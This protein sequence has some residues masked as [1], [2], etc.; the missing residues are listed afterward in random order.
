MA[1][2]A[3]FVLL[4]STCLFDLLGCCKKIELQAWVSRENT[5]VYSDHVGDAQVVSFNLQAGDIC[6][7]GRQE[8]EKVYRYTEV[9]CPGK[10]YGWVADT[11]FIIIDRNHVRSQLR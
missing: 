5:P 1:R 9:L 3:T 2:I 8:V 6:V 10:G 11:N 7:P 4:L